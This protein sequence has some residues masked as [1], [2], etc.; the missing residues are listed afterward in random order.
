MNTHSLAIGPTPNSVQNEWQKTPNAWLIPEEGELEHVS[1]V[2]VS[3]GAAQGTGFCITCFRV[4]RP[5]THSLDTQGLLQI[6]KKKKKRLNSLLLLQRPQSIAD[7]HQRE[8]E[9]T[10]SCKKNLAKPL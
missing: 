7:R 5:N 8:Q 2:L 3:Q 4:L 9:I 6:K 1:N 10:S